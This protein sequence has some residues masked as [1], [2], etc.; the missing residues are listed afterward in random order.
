MKR[1]PWFSLKLCLSAFFI[2]LI[3]STAYAEFYIV[4][5]GMAVE[6]FSGCYNCCR[7]CYHSMR[8]VSRHKHNESGS[9]QM[10]EYAWVGD[11]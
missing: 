10:E 5:P 9:G 3:C 11:P 1:K 8:F 2:S 7:P 6:C 4:S